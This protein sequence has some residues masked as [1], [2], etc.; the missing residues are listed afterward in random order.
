MVRVREAQLD[1]SFLPRYSLAVQGAS[2][3]G[4]GSFLSDERKEQ[5]MTYDHVI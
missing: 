1:V 5:A 4:S 2:A 3:H